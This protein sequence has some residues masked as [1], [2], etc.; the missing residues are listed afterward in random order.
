MARIARSSVQAFEILVRRHQRRI[1]N[2]IYSSI[3]ERIMMVG[4][5]LDTYE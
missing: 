1:L 3:G 2:L 5:D 4:F